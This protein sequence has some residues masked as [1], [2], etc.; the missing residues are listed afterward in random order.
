MNRP[1]IWFT[2]ILLL[3]GGGLT[4]STLLGMFVLSPVAAAV[5]VVLAALYA[6]GVLALLRATPLWPSLG[7]TA[8]QKWWILVCLAWGGGFAMVPSYVAGPPVM[9]VADALGWEDA[10]LSFGGAYPE[11]PGKAMGVVLILLCFRG[12]N[13]PWHGLVTGALVGLGF[14]A[15]ENLTYG[16]VLGALHP[17]ADLDGSLGIWFVRLIYGPFLHIIWT[18][19]AGWGIGQALFM[20]RRSAAGRI[21][22][23][24]G[25]LGVSFIFHF[26]WNYQ[27][28]QSVTTATT[29]A[30]WVLMYPVAIWLLHRAWQL[31]RDD[32]SYTYTPG[33]LTSF[34]QLSAP[35]RE[36]SGVTTPPARGCSSSTPA[37]DP[38]G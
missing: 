35:G 28:E 11:E 15:L 12:L 33:A 37:T 17:V 2:G 7:T 22:T 34:S 3:A 18:A 8:T 36:S 19:L 20:A 9:D 5:G 31:A 38:S 32:V 30:V 6:L 4:V 16:V 27:G 14:E 29:Y 21:L 23:A 13:R 26:L 10:S 1:I 24:L 25:W